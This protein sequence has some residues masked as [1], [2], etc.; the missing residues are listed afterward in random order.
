MV[1]TNWVWVPDWNAEDKEEPR[2]IY[3]RKKVDIYKVPE[4]LEVQISADSRY[5]LYL[6]GKLIEIGPSKGD[7]KIWYYDTVDLAQHLKQG[8][9]ILSVVVL[10]YPMEHTKGNSG[11]FRTHTPGFYF[12]GEYLEENGDLI[13]LS[14][15]ESWKCSREPNVKILPEQKVL[16]HLYFLEEASG[17]P[18]A[19]GWMKDNYEDSKWL[20]AEV[21]GWQIVIN[22]GGSP[23]NLQA[24]TIPYMNK[25]P[26]KFEGIIVIRD[27]K[28]KESEWNKMLAGAGEITILPHSNE[29][30]EISAGELMTGFLKLSVIHGKGAKIN[31]LQSE[32]YVLPDDP[33]SPKLSMPKKGDRLDYKNGHLHGFTDTYEVA[34]IGRNGD[35]E[36]YEPF[37]FRTFRFIRLE[38]VTADEPLT[39][40]N[41]D[42]QETGY[43]LE[44]KTWVKTSD[45]S[46]QAIWDISERSLRR[47]M[48]ETYED[49][50]FYEQLQYAMDTRSQILFTYMTSADDRLARKCFD[51]FRRSQR[52]DGMISCC[53][54]NYTFHSIPGFSIYY[55]MMLYDHM[56]YF[57]DR[58]LIRSYLSTIDGILEYFHRHLTQEGIVDKTGGLLFRDTAWSFIDWTTQWNDTSGV[59]SASLS[60][61]ITM[62]SLLYIMGLEY[63]AQMASFAGR[64]GVADEYVVRAAEVREAVREVC[65]SKNG[66]IQDGPGINEYSQHCQVFAI[67]TDTI[68]LEQGRENLL[69]TLKNKQEYTQC[70]VAMAFYLY[71]ALEKCDLY[72]Y[73]NEL[74]DVW[75][76]M[77]NNN[78]TTCV[79]DP[80][81]QRSDCHAWGALALYEL[82]AVILGV[83]PT[84]PG[85]EEMEVK[86]VPGHFTWAE[87]EVITP[88]GM[89]KV[90]WTKVGDNIELHHQLIE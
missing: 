68:E 45:Q 33:D 12:T 38:I 22:K 19:F 28:V 88:K 3:F 32:G 80:V 41:F 30:V 61:P 36:I 9:N 40:A 90:K 75:R 71:R 79:E 60:G 35:S 39:L 5:K 18:D 25:I 17:N 58:E 84:K 46:L 85:F 64:D 65:M 29:V 51:D 48:H 26:R 66:M 73:T 7:N 87:G 1:R 62:E 10:R 49:C 77:V 81:V 44:V 57:G 56:M 14:A 67:L 15:D 16:A 74:W 59:P 86:P 50:P 82:P 42:Y 27:S 8:T 63:A 69:K 4:K 55:I 2:I 13:S 72:E 54:P 34:G 23:G 52:Y 11:I 24:R 47:C 76:D 78:L 37:W 83:R 53:Y 31:I 21:L 70:S 20:S 89:V 6:N 43:P